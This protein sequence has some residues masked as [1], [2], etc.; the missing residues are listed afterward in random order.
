[1]SEWIV[2]SLLGLVAHA[3]IAEAIHEGGS[4]VVLPTVAGFLAA[5]QL[6]LTNR[7]NDGP[8]NFIGSCAHADAHL[9]RFAPDDATQQRLR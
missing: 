3:M 5:L 4:R 8:R 1:M 9:S 7:S 2:V 6:A